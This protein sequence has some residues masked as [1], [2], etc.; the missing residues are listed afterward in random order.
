VRT[1]V[2]MMA[3][4]VAFALAGA[5]LT[6]ASALH[7]PFSGVASKTSSVSP[8][9]HAR[10]HHTF[11]MRDRF[12]REVTRYGDADTS[13]YHIKHV[14]E[15]QY[16]LRWAGFLHSKITTRFGK[17]TRRAVKHYQR[18]EQ[19]PVTGVAT[20]RTW[21]HLLRDTVRHRGQI[22]RICKRAGWHAC[23]DRKMHQVTLWHNG[24]LHNTWLVRGGDYYAPTRVGNYHVFMRDKNH[25]SGITGTPMPYAQFFDGGEALHGSVF[26]M[27]PFVDH[28]LGCVNMYLQDARQ[29]WRLTAH[30][31]LYVSVYGAWS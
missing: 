1:R 29:L 23:Y 6:S 10:G 30:K 16:R 9:G 13:V 19:L 20:H 7:A 8:S 11:K 27:N 21:A 25:V 22:P 15:L 2:G 3:A 24:R 12:A 17:K 5:P 14:T 28:S 4:T 31:R 18:S 26:M